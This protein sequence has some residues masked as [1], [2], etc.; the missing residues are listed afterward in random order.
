MASLG[1]RAS[2]SSALSPLFYQG[3][4]IS[5]FPAPLLEGG[6]GGKKVREKRDKSLRKP[7]RFGAAKCEWAHCN[8]CRFG[9]FVAVEVAISLG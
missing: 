6:R 8:R 1:R 7:E 3:D 2:S 4:Q 9:G 5:L